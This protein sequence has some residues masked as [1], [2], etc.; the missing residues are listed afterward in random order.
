MATMTQDEYMNEDSAFPEADAGL[1][2]EREQQ[3]GLN[4]T[5][6]KLETFLLIKATG[7]Y[8]L[9]DLHALFD[10][11]KTEAEKRAES[12][13]ILDIT[14]VTGPIHFMDMLKLGEHCSRIWQQTLRIAIISSTRGLNEFFELVARNRG[15]QTAVVS[16][17]EAAVYWLT[18]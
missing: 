6:Q 7:Q 12:R 8:T 14:E 4:T 11:V 2:A 3:L 1:M 9:E 5:I 13:V 16:N 15:V 18:Y 17:T 10:D